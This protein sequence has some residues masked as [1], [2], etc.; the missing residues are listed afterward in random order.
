ML[1]LS[2]AWFHKRYGNFSQNI[3]RNSSPLYHQFQDQLEKPYQTEPYLRYLTSIFHKSTR[4]TRTTTVQKN[5]A[6]YT[7]LLLIW[8]VWISISIINYLIVADYGLDFDSAVQPKGSLQKVNAKNIWNYYMF[9]F[10][11]LWEGGPHQS[12]LT[13]KMKWKNKGKKSKHLR[14]A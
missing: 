9:Y 3:L 5:I 4:I 1:S 2:K 7:M 8:M 10:F 6:W 11:P 13:L 14:I 12:P